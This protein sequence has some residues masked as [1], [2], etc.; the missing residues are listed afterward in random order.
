VS[1]SGSVLLF[2]VSFLFFPKGLQNTV[3]FHGKLILLKYL[4]FCHMVIAARKKAEMPKTMF[5]AVSE[6][7]EFVDADLP[8]LGVVVSTDV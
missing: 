4:L 7:N 5:I 3:G 6:L 2:L 1:I 8:T